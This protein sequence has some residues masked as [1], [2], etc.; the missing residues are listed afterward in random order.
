MDAT[1]SLAV[2]HVKYAPAPTTP[3]LEE[4]V[5]A[6][7]HSY[8]KSDATSNLT[9]PK[10]KTCWQLINSHFWASPF[11]RP[12]GGAA[13][14]DA[15][16]VAYCN[17]RHFRANES[18]VGEQLFADVCP[19]LC[20][21]GLLRLARSRKPQALCVWCGIIWSPASGSWRG[22]R[23]VPLGHVHEL[24]G[25]ST[26]LHRISASWLC[27]AATTASTSQHGGRFCHKYVK[28]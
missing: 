4:T 15:S 18:I 24:F 2:A 13:E 21:V 10:T 16:L 3:A 7:R 8:D 23:P 25:A 27:V 12:V 9:P 14:V 6:L 1:E 17:L 11:S 19:E 5:I 20:R 28:S 22:L 26:S